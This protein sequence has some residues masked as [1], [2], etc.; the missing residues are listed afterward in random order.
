MTADIKHNEQEPIREFEFLSPV[1]DFVTGFTDIADEMKNDEVGISCSIT[2]VKVDLPVE[3]GVKV[4]DDGNVS[5][6]SA[7]PTQQIDTT[8]FPVLHRMQLCLVLEDGPKRE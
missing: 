1:V 3:I 2:D 8:I 4:D 5:L 6:A 7:P